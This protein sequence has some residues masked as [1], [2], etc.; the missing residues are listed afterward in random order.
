MPIHESTS[1]APRTQSTGVCI[2]EYKDMADRTIK[3][4]EAA[5]DAAIAQS[6]A[7]KK[8]LEIEGEKRVMQVQ[9]AAQKAIA[10]ANEK[11]MLAEIE[12][13]RALI[14]EAQKRHVA[15]KRALEVQLEHTKKKPKPTPALTKTA[16]PHYTGDNFAS[17]TLDK[18]KK[19]E[20]QQMAMDLQMEITRADGLHITAPELRKKI[21]SR[22]NTQ[23]FAVEDVD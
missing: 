4:M 10:N 9:G 23:G 6:E 2:H 11:V 20:L 1:L 5:K 19:K 12:H 8:C 22:K 15:E 7:E 16:S 18:M 3:A 14:E 17:V 21:Y 13:K